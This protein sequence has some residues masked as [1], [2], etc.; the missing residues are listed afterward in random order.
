MMSITFFPIFGQFYV[1][2][3]PSTYIR[4]ME[5]KDIFE[6]SV[7][8]RLGIFHGTICCRQLPPQELLDG[9]W[10]KGELVAAQS[11]IELRQTKNVQFLKV[12]THKPKKT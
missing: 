10:G 8:V 11:R 7:A 3:F 9:W 4:K 2:Y 6:R 1:S 12:P 5:I